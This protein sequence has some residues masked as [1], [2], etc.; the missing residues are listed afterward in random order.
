MN[1]PL[2]VLI[3]EDSEDDAALVAHEL[4]RADDQAQIERVETGAGL[5]AALLRQHWD[6]VISDY[7]MPQFNGLAA[8]RM[9]REHSAELPF[10]IVS[11]TIGE[12]VAVE[13]MRAGANDYVMKGKLARLLPAVRRELREA[14]ARV[15]RDAE[16]KAQQQRIERLNRVRA[17]MSGINAL[18][19]RVRDREE[20]YREACRIT[21]EHGQFLMAWLGTTDRDAVQVKSVAMH[22]V[23]PDLFAFVQ[24]AM[25]DGAHGKSGI[26]ARAVRERHAVI[27]N[28]IAHDPDVLLKKECLQQGIYSL[29]VLPLRIAGEVVGVLVLYAGE[30]GFFDEEEMRL[31]QDLA[32]DIAFALDHIAKQE[33]LDYLAYYDSITGLANRTLFGERLAQ[34]LSAASHDQ[35]R[36]AVFVVDLDR[37][38]TINDTLGRQVGDALLKQM[39]Q[40]LALCSADPGH[41]AHIS[42]D[43]FAVVLPDV[44][45]EGEIA[46][47][48]QH[49]LRH[50][51]GEPFNLTGSE[52][53]IGAK[54]GIAMFPDDGASVDLLLRNAEA[55]VTRAKASGEQYIFYTEQMTVRIAEKLALENKLRQ[56][57]EREEFVLYYQPKVDLVHR[58]IAGVE[59][60]I[61]W[62]SPELGLV[63]PAQFI[64]LLEETGMILGVGAWVLKRA[65]LDHRHWLALGVSA[66]RIAVNV[67]V[68]QLR[69]RD[70]VAVVK[71]AIGDGTTRPGIDL[72]ITESLIMEDIQGSI[73]KLTALRDLGL[74]VTI[75]D[76]G[77]GYSSLGY[78]AKLPVQALKIDLSFI[79][80]MMQDADTMTLV[81]TI[82]SMAHS[83]RLRVI[84]E[85]V[86]TEQQAEALRKLG[87]DEMQGY[88]SGKPMP[89]E[90]MTAFLLEAFEKN[91]ALV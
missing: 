42:A 72:E 84:A 79:A 23:V 10:I 60:L 56:A 36:L 2:S 26:V 20:L 53:R 4:K 58:R 19:V 63:P 9:V 30:L 70:F 14:A 46:H 67:S 45:H 88:L 16:R 86:E 37:F 44:K 64:P 24:A 5:Q 17:V 66:P 82:I 80:A 43:R 12:E 69:R 90:E 91:P 31:L 48:L 13:A 15:T 68:S 25:H 28:D 32:S 21:V 3:V 27:S 22:G 59:A 6:I 87:C 33:K 34:F 40:R 11:A 73:E 1:Q 7:R 18:I 57:L 55:A 83:L 54:V 76:F 81:A 62:K 38:R 89:R 75:D 8:L 85:G 51:F 41:V 29:A 39:G 78:L 50:C 61:R 71:N 77:T 49:W 47:I 52:F 35:K 65:V 74:I